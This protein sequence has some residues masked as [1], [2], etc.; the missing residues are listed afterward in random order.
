MKFEK[1]VEKIIENM[2][3]RVPEDY[4]VQVENI[5]K[6]NGLMLT[7]LTMGDQ[8]WNVYPT[9]YLED[10]YKKYEEGVSIEKIMD[11]IWNMYCQSAPTGNWDTSR[12]MEW[13]RVKDMICPKLINY[14]ENRGLL[15][16]VPHRKFCD[17]AVVYYAVVDISETG[18]ASILIHNAHLDL[19]D[20]S[21]VDLYELALD[22][23]RRIFSITSQNLGDIVLELMDCKD[24]NSFDKDTL[25]P[26]IMVTNKMKMNGAA[27]ILFTDKLREIADSLDSDLYILPSSVHE[28]IIIA[29][30]N[31]MTV[32]ELKETV[33]YVN[34]NELRQEEILSDNMYRFCRSDGK[35]EI[36]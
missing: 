20:K 11:I 2:Q 16:T 9:I 19:W 29:T 21:E 32:E 13:C 7:G 33:C 35:V 5:Q 18:V 23:Y 1:F 10:F 26:M 25:V 12:F 4:M 30:D 36:I 31:A 6:N 8:R 3:K 27:A 24:A 28:I 22:N 15:K 14:S 34:R 17:L